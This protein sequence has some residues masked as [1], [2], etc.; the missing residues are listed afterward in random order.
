MDIEKN[1]RMSYF[2]KENCHLQRLLTFKKRLRVSVLSKVPTDIVCNTFYSVLPSELFV[3]LQNEKDL[4]LG[5]P[6]ISFPHLI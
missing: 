3:A 1:F 4:S 5:R 2:H 6:V